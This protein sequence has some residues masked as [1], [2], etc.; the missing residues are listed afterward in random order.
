[1]A[2]LSSCS[3]DSPKGYDGAGSVVETPVGGQTTFQVKTTALS[4]EVFETESTSVTIDVKN[5]TPEAFGAVGEISIEDGSGTTTYQLEPGESTIVHPMPGGKK[6][7]IITAGGQSRFR[8]EMR[9][10]FI[11]EITFD[12]PAMAIQPSPPRILIYGDSLATG[13]NVD[14]PS[15]E[16]W[17]V[18]LRQHHSVIVEA[19]GYRTLYDDASAPEKRSEFTSRISALSLEYV[20]LAMGTNDYGLEVWSAREFGEAYAATLDA[21]HSLNPQARV[22]AQSPIL[23][24][25]EPANFFGNDLNDYRQQIADACMARSAW[26]VFVDGRDPAFPQPEELD[27]DGIHLTTESSLKYAQAVLNILG[28]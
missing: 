18:L 5:T 7:V 26:C 15:A 27:E 3:S 4:A 1:M 20:W 22:F 17:P 28:K 25:E 8:G 13:G 19:Y 12:R 24:A 16:A 11:R 10:V 23:R 21:I 14:H 6:R 9:G 2:L